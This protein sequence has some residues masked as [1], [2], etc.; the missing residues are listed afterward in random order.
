[1]TYTTPTPPGVPDFATAQLQPGQQVLTETYVNPNGHGVSGYCGNVPSVFLMGTFSGSSTGFTLQVMWSLVSTP[2]TPIIQGDTYIFN[3]SAG[4]TISDCL[5][6]LAPYVYFVYTR[7][8]G[9]AP[10]NSTVTVTTALQSQRSAPLLENS[11]TCIYGA[12][13]VPRGTTNTQ[14]GTYIS[15]GLYTWS[16]FNVTA[17]TSTQGTLFLPNA[18]FGQNGV[19]AQ[20]TN[21][22]SN[23]FQT[24]TVVIGT[25]QPVWQL[26]NTNATTTWNVT[27]SLIGP[28]V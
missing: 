7:T 27:V 18:T 26:V 1:M 5:P 9:S 8:A 20:I 16:L 28:Q 25:A 13:I 14:Y 3:P 23:A 6:V 11:G 17:V 4:V 15:P 2:G 21:P 19:I 24:G 10:T 12:N 22:A